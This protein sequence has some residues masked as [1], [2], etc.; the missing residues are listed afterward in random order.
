MNSL[1]TFWEAGSGGQRLKDALF[2]ARTMQRFTYRRSTA[3]S[4]VLRSKTIEAAP[5]GACS[6]CA[7]ATSRKRHSLSEPNCHLRASVWDRF[8]GP[9]CSK[10]IPASRHEK[11]R[12][13]PLLCSSA[14]ENSPSHSTRPPAT[15][16]NLRLAAVDTK[17]IEWLSLQNSL[18][19]KFRV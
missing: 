15:D 7:T 12:R 10:L 4:A 8:C 16:P 18:N 11:L 6:S 14:P 5:R 9:F 17:G 13:R 3:V 1:A 19:P 2:P